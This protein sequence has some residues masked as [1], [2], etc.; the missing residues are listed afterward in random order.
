MTPVTAPPPQKGMLRMATSVLV[1]PLKTK[2]LDGDPKVFGNPK[3]FPLVPIEDALSKAYGYDAMIAMYQVAEESSCTRINK[4]GYQYI[5][6]MG[7]SVVAK[8]VFIDVDNP[9]HA[10]WDDPQD[11]EAAYTFVKSIEICKTAGFYSAHRAAGGRRHPSRP[12]V[13]RLDAAFPAAVCYTR[14]RKQV[15]VA[16]L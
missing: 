10:P 11:I 9:D 1:L 5:N 16:A 12:C 3:V 15:S 4:T 7:H 14:G 8:Y 2:G 13:H 6:D